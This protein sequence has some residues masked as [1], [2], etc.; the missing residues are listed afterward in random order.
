MTRL[1]IAVGC[2]AVALVLAAFLIGRRTAPA[3]VEVRTVVDETAVTRAV[4]AARAEWSRDVEDHTVTRTIYREGKPTERIV[5]V[6]REVHSGGAST[7]TTT[8]TSSTASTSRS[9]VVPALAPAGWRAG[10][11]G[12]WDLRAPAQRPDRWGLEADRRL[13]GPVWIG[14]RADTSRRAGLAVSVE[15]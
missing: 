15:W 4:E 6:D 8:A 5:Y 10:L 12:T 1:W 3:R 13:F 11:T 9:E 7:S 2:G 14:V